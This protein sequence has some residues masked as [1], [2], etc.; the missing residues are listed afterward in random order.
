MDPAQL[1]QFVLDPARQAQDKAFSNRVVACTV[2]SLLADGNGFAQCI[3]EP[4]EISSAS[5]TEPKREAV[6]KQWKGW[7]SQGVCET[8]EPGQYC[9]C[10]GGW[11][12]SQARYGTEGFMCKTGTQSK[13]AR[14]ANGEVY[15]WAQKTPA[16]TEPGW[17]QG[18][19]KGYF[20]FACKDA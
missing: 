14:C 7:A 20:G 9:T 15:A 1:K 16:S 6:P 8:L 12:P 13:P 17:T 4:L 2:E 18:W 11:V 5:Y 3:S 19:G 10:D